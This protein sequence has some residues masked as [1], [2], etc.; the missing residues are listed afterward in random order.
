MSIA[1]LDK[2]RRKAHEAWVAAGSPDKGELRDALD[3][4]A[5]AY[6]AARRADK[7]AVKV[8][9]SRIDEILNARAKRIAENKRERSA[10]SAI[11]QAFAWPRCG[12]GFPATRAEE[13]AQK[14]ALEKFG[15]LDAAMADNW[16]F[17]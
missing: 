13:E 8:D 16:I 1:A 15:S 11:R 17:S 4:A 12:E 5:K 7:P 2:A 6:A 10:I 14:W 9:D 3:A